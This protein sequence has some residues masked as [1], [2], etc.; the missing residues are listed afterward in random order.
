VVRRTGVKTTVLVH[1]GLA[2][3]V[4]FVLLASGC[5]GQPVEVIDSSAEPAGAGSA[6]KEMRRDETLGEGGWFKFTFGAVEYP[7]EWG[8]ADLHPSIGDNGVRLT[9]L[10]N[11]IGGGSFPLLRIVIFAE[12][13]D[14]TALQGTTLADQTIVLKMEKKKGRG[15]DGKVSITFTT[16]G[17]GW[18]EGSFNGTVEAEGQ[19]QPIQGSF[20]AHL[21]L[22]EKEG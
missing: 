2:T 12:A 5:G 19:A 10:N 4:L 15:Y 17:E 18:I 22:P 20:K 8:Y 21:N 6:F 3:A 16:V 13:T 11:P 9:L 7:T 14:V 1:G